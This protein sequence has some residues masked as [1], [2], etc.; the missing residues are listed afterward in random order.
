PFLARR[1]AGVAADADVEV[2]DERELLRE[3]LGFGADR[4]RRGTGRSG[5][6][7]RTGRGTQRRLGD[8]TTGAVDDRMRCN[9]ALEPADHRFAFVPKRR[10]AGRSAVASTRRAAVAAAAT[11]SAGSP[12][13]PSAAWT[14]RE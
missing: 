14:R 11:P 1:D 5:V 4:D 10:V 13:A 3:R 8:R 9:Q 2:N 6:V 12:A 7:A